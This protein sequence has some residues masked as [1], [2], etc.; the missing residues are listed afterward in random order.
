MDGNFLGS[1]I[2]VHAVENYERFKDILNKMTCYVCLNIVCHPVECA[3]CET[4]LCNDCW[5]I[6]LI[7][8]KKCVTQKCKGNVRKANKF[9]REILSELII[10]CEFCEKTG[11]RYKDI[12]SHLDKCEP[13]KNSIKEQLFKTIKDKDEK[14]NEIQKQIDIMKNNL[15]QYVNKGN[16][17]ISYGGMSKAA[18]RQALMT[19]ALPVQKKM[20]LYDACVSGNANSFKHLVINQKYPML[21]EVSAENYYWTPLHYSM[22][23]GQFEITKFIL[24]ALRKNNQMEAAM[25]LESADGRCPLLCLLRSNSINSDKKKDMLN[26]VLANFNFTISE[27]V[28]REVKLR[29]MERIL[30]HYNR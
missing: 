20:E 19:F 9:V 2:K 4:L 26:K 21:E 12:E 23:Y 27:D 14:I 24:E 29:D 18:L 25:R 7:A 10:V 15:Q 30:R 11:I 6:M 17:K 3:L 28:R 1:G 5:Q 8:G 13:Y 22:H 16:E